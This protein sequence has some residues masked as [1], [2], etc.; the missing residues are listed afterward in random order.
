MMRLRDYALF[1]SDRGEE[2]S[3]ALET[4]FLVL[5]VWEPLWTSMP[6]ALHSSNSFLV[7]VR[8]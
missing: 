8:P 5:L 1:D 6:P 7:A 4:G 3:G 2:K